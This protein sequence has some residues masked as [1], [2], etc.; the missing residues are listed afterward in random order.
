MHAGPIKRKLQ[1]ALL[2]RQEPESLRFARSL[3]DDAV[4]Q[5]AA[6]LALD[7]TYPSLLQEG[8]VVNGAAAKPLTTPG[9]GT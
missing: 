6:T 8:V 5:Q 2:K 4:A 9:S 1:E 7:D 3:L